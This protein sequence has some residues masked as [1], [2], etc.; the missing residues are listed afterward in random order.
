MK[1]DREIASK[2]LTDSFCLL[3]GENF[4]TLF[5]ENGENLLI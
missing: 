2:A 1:I 4:R 3:Y 5:E